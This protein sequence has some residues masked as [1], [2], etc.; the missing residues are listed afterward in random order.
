MLM[1]NSHNIYNSLTT[2][3]KYLTFCISK[4]ALILHNLLGDD[5]TCECLFLL[6]SNECAYLQSKALHP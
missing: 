4:F 5:K 1:K 2:I 3:I 6:S